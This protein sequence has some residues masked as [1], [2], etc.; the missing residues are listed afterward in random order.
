MFT[1]EIRT[2]DTKAYNQNTQ[3]NTPLK[4]GGNAE[5]VENGSVNRKG[6]F[7]CGGGNGEWALTGRIMTAAPSLD[8]KPQ[9]EGKVFVDIIVDKNGRVVSATVNEAKSST[10]AIGKAKLYELA[11]K[12]AKSARFSSINDTMHQKG[13]ITLFF[14]PR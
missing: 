4:D 8:E 9:E 11:T 14:K 10:S 1:K 5:A 2:P 7:N 3:G 13:S 6:L 12:A